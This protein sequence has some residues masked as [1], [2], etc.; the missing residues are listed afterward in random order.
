MMFQIGQE[1]LWMENP[2]LKKKLKQLFIEATSKVGKMGQEW[3]SSFFPFFFPVHSFDFPIKLRRAIQPVQKILA[4]IQV[5]KLSGS[6]K[7]LDLR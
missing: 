4:F 1:K 2:G 5:I 6:Y 3:N 7:K